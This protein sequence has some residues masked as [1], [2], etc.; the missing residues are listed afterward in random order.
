MRHSNKYI[1]HFKKDTNSINSLKNIFNDCLESKNQRYDAF[2]KDNKSIFQ[3]YKVMFSRYYRGF[4]YVL[5]NDTGAL[6]SESI[7]NY[8]KEKIDAFLEN[9]K[10][11]KK[12]IEINN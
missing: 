3:N 10:I 4:Y 7:E 12:V 8:V 9:K 2:S 5:L 1:E 6:L 11:A